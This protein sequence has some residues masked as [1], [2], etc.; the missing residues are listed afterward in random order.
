MHL[1]I[2]SFAFGWSIG[3]PGHEPP[4]PMNEKDL[5]RFMRK[6]HL[7]YLQIGDHIPV[8]EFPEARLTAFH[9]LIN[10]HK[11]R[12]ELGARK[13]TPEHLERYIK[14]SDYFSSSLLRFVI[15]GESYAPSIDDIITILKEVEPELKKQKLY[16]GI[17]NHDRLKASEFESIIEACGSE[18]IG[19]CL[20]TVNS[21]GAGEG[22]K[23]V[24]EILAPYT[25]NLH[26]KDFNIIRKSHMMGFDV[27]GTPAG[28]GM[29]NI[30]WLIETLLPYKRCQSVVLEQWIPFQKD[31]ESTMDM[32]KEWAEMG[33]H[34]LGSMPY[35]NDLS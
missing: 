19:I 20:D 33:L 15:D 28:V 16:L 8:H 24:I 14:L 1:G 21:L 32:E 2:S 4:N 30:P 3:V 29:I 35:F 25:I 18:Y 7:N 5:Y 17:E 34:F 31:L 13:M 27:V 10:S 12:L 11:T 9:E 6:H 26:L 23:E 22:L